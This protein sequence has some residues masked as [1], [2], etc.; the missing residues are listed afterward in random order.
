MDENIKFI[1]DYFDMSPDQIKE[2]R[3]FLYLVRKKDNGFG[4]MKIDIKRKQVFKLSCMIESKPII[5]KTD[6]DA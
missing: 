4:Y 1:C 5:F 2:L 3:N 6:K